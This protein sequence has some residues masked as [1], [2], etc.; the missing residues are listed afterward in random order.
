MRSIKICRNPNY[1]DDKSLDIDC[2]RIPMLADNTMLWAQA[3]RG[4][5][6][7][8]S[9]GIGDPKTDFADKHPNNK[10]YLGPGFNVIFSMNT[11]KTPF[12]NLTVRKALS[13]SLDRDAMHSE[14][15]Y[16][17]T[18]P[19]KYPVAAGALYD[20]WFDQE[21]LASTQSLMQYDPTEAARILDAAGIVDQNQDGWR[22][23]VDGTP[24]DI[25]VSVPSGW[26]DWVNT[27]NR[28]IKN[29]RSIGINAHLFTPNDT[30]WRAR[31]AGG[32]FDVYIQVT[33]MASNPVSPYI[34]MFNTNHMIPG[35][36]SMPAMHQY[37]LPEVNALIQQYLETTDQAQHYEIMN[38]IY[39]LVAQH[40]PV[41]TLFSNPD[42]YEYN[43]KD[44]TGF[45]SRDDPFV[46]PVIWSDNAERLIHILNIKPRK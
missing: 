4:N 12:N 46:R 7:W 17:L 22:D 25:E 10:F 36:V 8:M 15:T 24:I 18:T 16:G 44:F 19:G 23:N 33:G 32:D 42:W 27:C 1:F 14:D 28:A 43:D 13:I 45:V 29:W 26:T 20:A 37:R 11:T 30:D 21:K 9:I 2:I 34:D 41:I 3:R 6:N 40:L 5:I 35:Q 31:V 39:L 38:D